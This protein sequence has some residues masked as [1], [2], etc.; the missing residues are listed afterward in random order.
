M[1]LSL[2]EMVRHKLD[3]ELLPRAD[4][5]KL[6]AGYGSGEAC[7]ACEQ[8]ILKAQIEYELQYA[9]AVFRLHAGCHGLWEAERR[10][11]RY[12]SGD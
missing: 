12:S 7:A 10:R 1:S 5:V 6:W 9:S 4:P 8:T 3:I 11:R 2:A